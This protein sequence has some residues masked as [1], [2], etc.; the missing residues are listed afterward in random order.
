MISEKPGVKEIQVSLEEKEAKISYSHGDVTPDQLAD[1]IED[2]GFDAFVKEVNGQ[3]KNVSKNKSD[4]NNQKGEVAIQV[5]G[6][7][8]V[9][10]EK[11]LAKCVLHVQVCLH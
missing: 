1:Y 6:G 7:G 8:D 3:T 9:K 10:P 4:S 5:N 2:M 11:P